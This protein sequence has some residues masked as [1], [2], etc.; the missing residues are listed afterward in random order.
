VEDITTT[1]AMVDS[2][3]TLSNTS[4]TTVLSS[5]KL[6]HTLPEMELANPSNLISLEPSPTTLM[7]NTL[8]LNSELPSTNHQSLLPSKPINTFSKLINPVSSPQDVE[9]TSI[10]VSSLLDMEPST[11]PTSSSSKTPGELDGEM[12]VTL[13]S[14]LP[15]TSAVSSTLPH[16]H[17]L[18]HLLGF[19]LTFNNNPI[20]CNKLFITLDHLFY[21]FYYLTWFLF[22]S[23]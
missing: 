17:K 2:W 13:E 20:Q 22:Q 7:F 18:E 11:D 19:C 15:T 12:K 6:I 5:K 10:T 3:T 4:E 8:K 16:T 23:Y 21:Y 9:P 1:D 14:D